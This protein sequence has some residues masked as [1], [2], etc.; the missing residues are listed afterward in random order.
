MTTLLFLSAYFLTIPSL[1]AIIVLGVIFEAYDNNFSIFLGIA[2]AVTAYF[3]F[4]TTL[5]VLAI[6][7][8]SYFVTG[9]LWSFWRYKRY[10]ENEINQW[11]IEG[12]R[13]SYWKYVNER[14]SPRACL[15][16]ITSWIIIWPLSMIENVTG[17]VVRLI[18]NIVS[19]TLKS[20][21]NK[22][23]QSAISNLP[24]KPTEEGN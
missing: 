16:R 20:V 17:D 2:A 12:S 15:S 3:M 14:I 18:K 5:V 9:V 23:Y 19:E 7:G 11:V 6:I 24:Q 13:E 10:T 8:V 21:Y 1:I 22:I 4:D